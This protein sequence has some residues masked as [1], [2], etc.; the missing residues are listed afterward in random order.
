MPIVL[1]CVAGLMGVSALSLF[2]VRRSAATPAVYGTCLAVSLALGA[3]SLLSIGQVASE[4]VLPL[5]LPWLGAHFR[6][7]PLA[8]AFLAI[9]NFGAAGASLYALGYGRHEAEPA[10]VLPFYP[11][12][13]AAMNLVIVAADAYGFLLAWELMSLASWA[14]VM[15]RHRAAQTSYAGFVYLIMASFG[16]F[17]LLFAFG[18]LAGAHGDYAFEAIRAHHLSPGLAGLAL[19]L[20]VIGAGSKAG[21]VP[22][23]VWLP[24]AHPAA[25][26]HVSALMSGVMTKVAIYAFIRIAFDLMGDPSWWW[27]LPAL[28]LGG[29]TAAIGVLYALMET[30][31]KRVLAYSTIE[32]VGIIFIAIGLALAFKASDLA[33]A[34]ALALTAAL[35]HALNHTLF[36]S[37]LFFG[38]G[39]VIVATG[40]QD[41]E[42]LG[43]LI[44]RMPVSSAAFLAASMAIS[45]LPPFNGFASEWLIFQ[46][47]LV[48][49]QLPQMGLKLLVPA[50]GVLLALAAAFA[51]A[52]FVRAF[53][54]AY[55]GRARTAA[56]AQAVEADRWS[57][58]AMVICAAL[59]LLA[60]IF[61]GIVIDWFQPAATALVAGH[62]PP[63]ASI[64]WLSIVP[65]SASRSSYNGLLLFGFVAASAGFAAVVIHRFA[66]RAVRKAPF[67]DCGYPG[68]GVAAQYSATSLAQPIRRVFA[69]VAFAARE[70]VEMPPPGDPR[71]AVLRRFLRDPVWH[72]MYAPV[73]GAVGGSATLLNHIQ[74]FTI[75][76]YLSFVFIALVVLLVV[77][78][79]WG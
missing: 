37:A 49:P 50:V 20:A 43:G 18:L 32:N 66:S 31:L 8:C 9:I 41:M 45:A 77:L 78:A 56:A 10:R 17:A 48:S 53:G 29:A 25:P 14:L 39:T 47:I 6:L 62:M 58:A 72:F 46:S 51:A 54:A 70:Q 33:G 28:L 21:L 12:F 2:L 68:L 44:R 4:T 19:V 7:D 65:V 75:R 73:A 5:G 74:F 61:P 36:K 52:C 42:R 22:L 3:T 60:G 27:S 23:H 38:A 59:C 26:S 40:E 1:A 76:R 57:L 30:D 67:W 13:L 35:F 15:A 69:T 63:Q 55:L 71:P 34:A 79:L 64:P 11:A 24:L 16:T